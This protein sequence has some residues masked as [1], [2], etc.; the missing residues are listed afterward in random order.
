MLE[1][2]LAEQERT[3]WNYLMQGDRKGLFELYR[4]FYRYLFDYGKYIT[5]DEDLVK[6]CIQALFLQLWEKRENLS[7]ANNVRHYI[8]ISF[9]RSL[10]VSMQKQQALH[11]ITVGDSIYDDFYREDSVEDAL[12]N[13]QENENKI[14]KLGKAI[15]KLPARQRE[16][17]YLKYYKGLSYEEIAVLSQINVRTAYNQIHTA[18]QSLRKDKSIKI[19][20]K[21]LLYAM[22]YFAFFE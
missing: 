13:A 8:V 5:P 2:S 22:L 21:H 9:K 11:S 1:K 14:A 15:L 18:I 3:Y 16:L 17:I 10:L 6:D 19:D 7:S 4:L 12:I 20:N